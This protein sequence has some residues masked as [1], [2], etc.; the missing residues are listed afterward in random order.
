MFYLPIK[1]HIVECSQYL[2]DSTVVVWSES[3]EVNTTND[4]P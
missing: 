3:F 4:K 1:Q 2:Y